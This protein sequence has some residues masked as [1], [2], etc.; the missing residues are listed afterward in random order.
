MYQGNISKLL[1]M[2]KLGALILLFWSVSAFCCT[3]V[4]ISGKV[5]EDGRPVMMKHRDTDH[6]SNEIRWFQGEKYSFIGLVN[7]DVPFDGEVWAGTNSAG[8]S[9]MNT[10]TYDLKED[11]VPTEQMDKEG[12][13]MYRALE[14]CATV[15]DFEHFLDTLSKPMGIEANFGVIDANGGAMYYEVDNW[16]IRAKYDVNEE[17][18]GYRVVT[19]FTW[20]G[21]EADRK[22]VDRYQKACSLLAETCIPISEW[23]HDFLINKISR[24]GAPILRSIS[25][26]SIVFEGDVMWA[27]LGQADKNPY[28]PYT[29]KGLRP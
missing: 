28:K 9:I 14:V 6:L 7:T 16:R 22:G 25:T 23:D 29:E 10:A 19:N 21:R 13:V 17:P 11:D 18:S 12:Y 1:S 15:L 24:S 27:S 3:S 26:A 20:S 5:R 4:I 2:R 8:F